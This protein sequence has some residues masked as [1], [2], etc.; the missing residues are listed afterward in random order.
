MNDAQ[1]R[2]LTPEEREHYFPEFKA[3]GNEVRAEDPDRDDVRDD[4]LREAA[5]ALDDAI[6]A[7]K[8]SR[9][10]IEASLY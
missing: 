9:A 6:A 8:E 2:N 5:H 1:R 7:L 4:D 3:H 10:V